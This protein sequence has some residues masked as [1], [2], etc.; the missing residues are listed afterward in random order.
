MG[1][2]KE[3]PRKYFYAIIQGLV[4][5]AES[6]HLTFGL[7]Y[8]AALERYDHARSQGATHEDAQLAAVA[9]ALKATWDATLSRPWA[10]TDPNKNRLTLVRTVVWYLEQFANDPMETIQ[11][12]NGKP[13]VELSFRFELE[14]LTSS[15]EQYL[16]CGHMDRVVAFAG[17]NYIV[18]RKT[19]KATLNPEFFEK[20][21]PDNQFS[22]Y[23]VAGRIAYN[24]PLAGLI[25]D[26]A[27][28]AVT[29]SRFLRGP[30]TRSEAQLDEW[31]KDIG[32]YLLQ[33][34]GYAKAVH[35]PMNDKSCGNYGGC[36]YREVCSK[37]PSVRAEWLPK[38]MQKR[39]WDPLQVR[40]DI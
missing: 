24:I 15:G 37:P 38:L 35:W 26:G 27:Q 17:H 40:G 20:F 30:V 31:L 12:A 6:V 19:T 36:P 9:Y 25:V 3:C 1:A 7:H 21:S 18:D 8:H 16:W 28:V 34:E 23:M 10:S 33:A 4:P 5:R 39:V 32:V 22:G 14:Q 11:L 2:L 29:F 13:A